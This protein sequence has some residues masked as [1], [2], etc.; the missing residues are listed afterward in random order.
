MDANERQ[1]FLSFAF[2]GVHSR[3]KII[4]RGIWTS[5]FCAACLV[6]CCPWIASGQVI[7]A[8]YIGNGTTG[9]GQDSGFL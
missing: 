1:Y 2:I 3:F 6:W 9:G 7:D 8:T 5:I 4:A